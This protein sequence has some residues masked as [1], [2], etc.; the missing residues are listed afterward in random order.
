MGTSFFNVQITMRS[1]SSVQAYL[2]LETVLTHG[3]VDEWKTD[4]FQVG[5]D[6]VR[7]TIEL[8]KLVDQLDGDTKP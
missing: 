5:E 7:D 8:M 2:D 4:T 1:D 6:E 3:L